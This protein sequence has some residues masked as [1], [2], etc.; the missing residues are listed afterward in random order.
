MSTISSLFQH[1]KNPSTSKQHCIPFFLLLFAF[2]YYG[3]YYRCS[4]YLA[5]EGGVEGVT[6]LRLM[7]G[8]IPFLET[9]MNYNLFW[10]YP[11][12]GLFKIFG[13]SYTVLRIFFFKEYVSSYSSLKKTEAGIEA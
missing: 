13:P 1:L 10:F 3:S 11:I 8:N 7:Q 9:A 2:C 6:A 12:V 4:L 5:G